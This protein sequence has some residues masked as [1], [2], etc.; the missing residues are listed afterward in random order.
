MSEGQTKH[1]ELIQGVIG[2]MAQNSFVMK[3]WAVTLVSAILVVAHKVA[4]WEYLLVA[5]LPT[6]VFWGFDAFYLRQERLFRSLYD[7]VRRMGPDTWENERFSLDPAPHS[8]GVSGWL[9]LCWSRSVVW[10]YGPMVLLIASVAFYT[11]KC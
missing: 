7:A 9:R 10:L 2:R 8:K 3:G 6:F 4:G 1:L 11:A 5:L